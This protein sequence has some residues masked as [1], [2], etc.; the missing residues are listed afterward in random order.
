MHSEDSGFRTSPNWLSLCWF[1][2]FLSSATAAGSRKWFA[3]RVRPAVASRLVYLGWLGSGSWW[4]TNRIAVESSWNLW[5]IL[6]HRSSPLESSFQICA[7]LLFELVV[8]STGFCKCR[9]CETET[10]S[11]SVADHSSSTRVLFIVHQSP[12]TSK[13]SKPSKPSKTF[14]ITHLDTIYHDH[15]IYIYYI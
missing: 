13:P 3:S 12:Q 14:Y 15:P 11:E 1:V 4:G 8:F 10:S 2:A 7:K 6:V 5:C 9:G